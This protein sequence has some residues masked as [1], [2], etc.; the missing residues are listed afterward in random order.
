[1]LFQ[2]TSRIAPRLTMD[3]A[4]CPPVLVCGTFRTASGLGQSARLCLSALMA[5]GIDAH[6]IDITAGMMQPS[7]LPGSSLI[8]TSGCEGPGTII[9]HINSPLVPLAMARLGRRLVK[10]KRIIG[11]WAWELPEVPADWCHGVPFVHEIWTPSAFTAAAVGPIAAGRPVEI[12]PHPVAHGSGQ[13]PSP[14]KTLDRPFTVF[15]MF[16][17]ASGFERKNPLAA[18]AAFRKA[19]GE[20]TSAELIIKSSNLSAHPQGCELLR[21]HIGSAPNVFVVDEVLRSGEVD[22]LYARS[23]VVMSLH[24]SEGFGLVLAEAMLR[25]LPVIATDWSGNVDFLTAN[26]G[27]PIPYR[28]VASQ[29]PQDATY[30][31]PDMVWADADVNAA[32]DALRELRRNSDLAER[33][34]RAASD[35]ALETWS[36]KR[37]GARVRQLLDIGGVA[38]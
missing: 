36:A 22:A 28:L 29:D 13:H 20:D 3:A 35:F 1:M 12:V 10:E 9:L 14:D 5:A 19:F 23:D 7:D 34:G 26:T 32:A 30:H 16:N 17:A 15:V 33:L 21:E 25:G 38:A 18:V 2:V 6:A 11:Y 31:H 27:L 24:R 8:N 37:Y 4:P